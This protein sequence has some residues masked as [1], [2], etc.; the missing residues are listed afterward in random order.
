VE[1]L[2]ALQQLARLV[3]GPRRM[4]GQLRR[5]RRLDVVCEAHDAR[6]AQVIATPVGDALLFRTRLVVGADHEGNRIEQ[7]TGEIDGAFARQDFDPSAPWT[8]ETGRDMG[9]M[10]ADVD[11]EDVHGDGYAPLTAYASCGRADLYPA[12]VL[13]WLTKGDKRRR[14]A[15]AAA[16]VE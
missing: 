14:V 13:E 6:L 11:L 7:P 5:Y 4:F 10:L 3:G 1:D 12:A 8:A 9:L 15:H 16:A 2:P